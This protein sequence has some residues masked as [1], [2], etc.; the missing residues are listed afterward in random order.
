MTNLLGG[1]PM[2]GKLF[3]ELVKDLLL[4]YVV[5]FSLEGYLPNIPKYIESTLLLVVFI[6]GAYIREF[7][8]G[9]LL[10]CHKQS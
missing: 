7:I 10:T 2:T 8:K 4:A 3:L 1:I 6:F 5:Q 9:G